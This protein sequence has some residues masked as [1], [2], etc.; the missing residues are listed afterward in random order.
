MTIVDTESFFRAY[1]AVVLAAWRDDSAQAALLADP[2]GYTRRA[3]LPVDAGAT[4][5]IESGPAAGPLTKDGIVAAW[6]GSPGR[7]VLLL[8]AVPAV[9]LDELTDAQL[10]SVAA[11]VLCVIE[12]IC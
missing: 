6:T 11:G 9:D 12:I 4:V 1:S 10:N 3:G 7:H 5:S 2:S 8:P